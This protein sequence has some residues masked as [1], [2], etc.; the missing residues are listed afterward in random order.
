MLVFYFRAMRIFVFFLLAIVLH[1]CIAPIDGKTNATL[2]RTITPSYAKGFQIDEMSDSS[3][4]ITLFNLEK[5]SEK[6]QV[7][8]WKN[9]P[10][11]SIACLSTTHIAFL[12]KLGKIDILKAVGFTELVK[13]KHAVEKIQDGS[14]INLTVGHDTD[15]E[16][17]YAANPQL[18]FVYP[19]G[20]GSYQ[21]YLDKGIGVVQISE[22]LENHPLGRA[23]WIK[24]FGV[25]LNRRE[26]ADR[27]FSEIELRYNA[28]AS[29]VKDKTI[30]QPT[31]FTGSYDS[32]NW[33]APPGNSFAAHLLKDAGAR[34][35]YA[36]SLSS[37]NLVI[38]FESM[39]KTTFETDFCGKIIH[40]NEAVTVEK[41]LEGDERL[42]N[43]KAFKE[44][45]LFYCNTNE[46]D[47]HGDAIMEPEFMLADLIAI[48]NPGMVGEHNPKYFKKIQSK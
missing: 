33:F 24:V 41:M 11:T 25:L 46:C 32:G 27:I 34:Y 9:S 14:I 12:D 15:D 1:S 47:Y 35:I 2:V 21:K 45:N 39:I 13:N 30:D 7:I 43:I 22:Y 19:F 17:L 28:F 18:F 8:Q 4:R 29:M 5:P 20:G 26:E 3:T 16:K 23:E 40:S 38:P 37:G 6:L 48:F 31:V 10:L 36:D 42:M 44:N